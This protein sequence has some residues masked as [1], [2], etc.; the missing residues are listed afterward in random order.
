MGGG[1]KG[2]QAQTPSTLSGNPALTAANNYGKMATAG[3]GPA[4]ATMHAG[5]AVIRGSKGGIGNKIKSGGIGPGKVGAQSTKD[6]VAGAGPNQTPPG[7][8]GPDS[9]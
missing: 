7:Q 8:S 3:P 9:E 6:A 5:T 2:A 1:G 4:P